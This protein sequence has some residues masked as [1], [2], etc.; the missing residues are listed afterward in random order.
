[1]HWEDRTIATFL[2]ASMLLI[3]LVFCVVLLCV[4]R[5]LVQCSDVRYDF[6]IPTMFGSSL[7]PVDC[8]G[9]S[10]LIYVICGCLRIVMFN[11]YFAVFL[12]CF[13]SSCVPYAASFSALFIL[14]ALSVFSNVYSQRFDTYVQ[15][16][17]KQEYSYFFLLL[18]YPQH[19]STEIQ[20]LS[21]SFDSYVKT[22]V[23]QKYWYLQFLYFSPIHWEICMREW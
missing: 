23:N 3:F 11:T 20:L 4:F 1:M 10:C 2:M 22:I 19:W 9:C 13:S 16:I 5:F 18:I 14:F 21:E 8:R 12:Y 6:R 17:M 7:P 15:Q